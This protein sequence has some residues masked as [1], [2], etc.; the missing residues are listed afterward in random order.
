MKKKKIAKALKIL[1]A[2][3]VHLSD[4]NIIARLVQVVSYLARPRDFAEKSSITWYKEFH[5]FT[6]LCNTY[7][8]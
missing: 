3:N 7:L 1:T 5:G 6:K 8:H 4:K 2:L